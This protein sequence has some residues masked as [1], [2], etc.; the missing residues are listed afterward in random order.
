MPGAPSWASA[1]RTRSGSLAPVA[2]MISAPATSSASTAVRGAARVTTTVSG[3]SAA[4]RTSWES[5]GRRASESNTIRRGWRV[6]PSMRAVSCGS[7][8]SAVPIPTT[9]ASTSARQW[10]D[11]RRE[12]SPEIHFESPVRVATLPSSVI[13]DLN[14]THGR[15]VRACLRNGWLSSRARAASSPSAIVD[16]DALVA[17]DPEAAAGRLLRRVVGGDRRR[18][19]CRPRGSRRCTAACGRRGSTARA[20]RTASR[21]AGRRRRR[22]R[23]PRARRAGRRARRGSPPPGPCRRA[24][25]TA[26]TS[27]FGLVRPRPPSASSIAR[28]RCSW[29][30]SGAGLTTVNDI[31]GVWPHDAGRRR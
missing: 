31:D 16:L 17:Q 18:G 11:R 14:S 24:T 7:S 3:T 29:S 1:L 27:G 12:S 23:S 8:A 13:A 15:P 21:R 9:T 20:R 2:T 10:C 22:R 5:S 28:S 26:P 4:P 30:V 25:I 6:T 19:R